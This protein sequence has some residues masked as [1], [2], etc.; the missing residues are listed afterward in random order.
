MSK[1]K[2]KGKIQKRILRV[3]LI[4]IIVPMII[5]SVFAFS[6]ISALGGTIGHDAQNSIKIEGFK[7]LQ[8]KSI[9]AANYVNSWFDHI[10]VDLNRVIS[11][12]EDLFNNRIN[13]TETRPSYHQSGIPILPK[14]LYSSK[15][16]K[17]INTTFSDYTNSTLINM[18]V[19]QLIN[20]SAYLDYIFNP[21]YESNNIYITLIAGYEDGI[22]R[23]FPFIN[24]SRSISHNMST[25]EWYNITKSLVGQ[26]YFGS[27]NQSLIGPAI[28]ISQAALYDNNSIIGCCSIEVELSSLREYLSQIKVHETG[29]TVMINKVGTAIIHPDVPSTSIGSPIIDLEVNTTEFYSII[30]NI[31]DGERNTETF[32]KNGQTWIISYIPIGKGGYSIATIV[33]YL[34][35]IESGINLQNSISAL[36]IPMIAIFIIVLVI[37]FCVIIIAILMMSKRITSPITHLTDSIDN[38]VRGD[39]TKEIPIKRK[40]RSNEI[41]VLAQ[42]FQALLITMRLGNESYYQ[43]DNYLAFKN[44]SAALQLFKTTQNLK[45]QGICWNNLGNIFRNWAEFDKAKNA[46]D[47]AIEIAQQTN[48]NAGLSSRLN[49]RGL[50][51]LSEGNFGSAEEDFINALKIDEK[52]ISSDRIAT[53]KRNL[54]I[55]NLLKNDLDKSS[56]Y[57]N[58]AINIDSELSF[59]SNLAEDQFQSGRLELTKKNVETAVQNLENALNIA[60][61]FGNYPLM[62]NILKLLINIY[63]DQ[64]NTILLHKTEAKLGKISD[65][66]VRKKDVIFVI[67]QSG[68]M[69]DQNK[70]RAA[71][72]GAKEVFDT[73]INP[74]DSIAIIG[75]HSKVEHILTLTKKG[76]NV[77]KIQDIFTGITNTPYQT[78]FYD[79]L[80]LAIEML[81]N[82]PMENQKWIVALTDG[83]DNFS[84]N[85]SARTLSQYITKLD[86]PLNIILIGVGRELREVFTEMSLI[87]NSSIRGKYI[88][89]YSE[90]NLSKLIA[91]AFKRVKEIMASSEIEGFTPE[92]K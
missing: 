50:L 86:Y 52:M 32:E 45:G 23:V 46:Y 47:K 44:Y 34:E 1:T 22:T 24:N 60:E 82:T 12:N 42:S 69:E 67:D 71:K 15:Y 78:A 53:R 64:D 84:K 72:K 79:A 73:V 18:F 31:I 90:Q 33:P 38:M 11:Y 81:N 19:S 91:D 61:E 9:D 29:Y 63:D 54:G 7:A 14:L 66:I 59:K 25:E 51:F 89:I 41:G 87:V 35:I 48:D 83:L 2:Q 76:G 28:L 21:I 65:I 17:Y 74:A 80:G 4:L 3:N 57:L 68:S 39:L 5:L 88:P 6:Q 56:K 75:F 16:N 36:N 70:I 58:D 26:T 49:N 77:E 27:V 13:L 62:M 37:L 20:K 55:L 8:N 30:D 10:S 92:E 85:Y 40:R 43:G